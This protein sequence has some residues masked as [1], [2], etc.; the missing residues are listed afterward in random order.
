MYERL[1]VNQ[2][3]IPLVIN[4][5]LPAC[6]QNRKGDFVPVVDLC[7][8]LLK[9]SDVPS[10]HENDTALL[11]GEILLEDA[12][13]WVSVVSSKSDEHT[14]QGR[15]FRVQSDRPFQDEFCS[16][17]VR[18]DGH[19]GKEIAL[20]FSSREYESLELMSLQGFGRWDS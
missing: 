18:N 1:Q 8:E 17:Y 3:L 9:G 12:A 5:I 13:P 15:R 16:K 19:V 11:Q 20:G 14:P 4:F 10:V 7:F 2:S 6:H